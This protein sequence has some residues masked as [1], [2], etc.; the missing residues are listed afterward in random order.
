MNASWSFR[1]EQLGENAFCSPDLGHLAVDG[2]IKGSGQ[3][4]GSSEGWVF[5]VNVQITIDL[6]VER[7]KDPMIVLLS[8]SGRRQV[9]ENGAVFTVAVDGDCS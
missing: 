6:L 3:S 2:D 9:G 4:N 5:S 8:A 1:L 7:P